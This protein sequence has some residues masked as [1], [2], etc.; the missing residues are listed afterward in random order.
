MY[1]LVSS[2][3]VG[4]EADMAEKLLLLPFLWVEE[5]PCCRKFGP[6]QFVCAIRKATAERFFTTSPWVHGDIKEATHSPSFSL[7]IFLYISKIYL[8]IRVCFTAE[9]TLTP[10][11]Q[12]RIEI[13]A[14]M[15]LTDSAFPWSKVC[16][17][18]CSLFLFWQKLFS[19]VNV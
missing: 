16:R 7:P 5:G 4:T 19:R 9:G 6:K 12:H 1:K 2:V 8:H 14:A 11:R 17:A 15:L 10:S 18:F 13:H 3:H